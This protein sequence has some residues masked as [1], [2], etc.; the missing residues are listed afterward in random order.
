M[1]DF[2]QNLLEKIK[3]EENVRRSIEERGERNTEPNLQSL[4]RALDNYYFINK[5]KIYCAFLS[6]SNI[7]SKEIVAY[8]ADDLLLIREI[9]VAIEAQKVS[10]PTLLIYNYI[11]I[12]YE[13]IG[14]PDRATDEVF[15]VVEQR[16]K[17]NLSYY[18]TD[19]KLEL[20]SFLTN[21]CAKRINQGIIEYRN[22]FFILNNQIINL[23]YH[24]RSGSKLQLQSSIYE[25]MIIIALRIQG[26]RCFQTMQT[27]GLTPNDPVNGF[28]DAFEWTEKFAEYYK[29]KLDEKGKKSHYPYCIALVEFSRANY[30]KAYTI[31]KKTQA[32]GMFIG[33]SSK[34]LYLQ[35]L[36]EVQKT[37]M[38]F[39][40]KEKVYI[41]DVLE[42]FRALI[43]DEKGRK[44]QLTYQI[45]FYAEF[46]RLYRKLY[47]VYELS[48]MPFSKD[49][50]QYIKEKEHL[51]AQIEEIRFSYKEW[52]VEKSSQLK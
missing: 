52:F 50:N 22:K 49:N 33:M 2:N 30:I 6:Y 36:Y 25:N 16:V 12:L 1:I 23:R 47:K 3:H 18:S 14:N 43:R 11:R 10:N 31:L 45:Q 41:D 19:E 20:Y 37:E 8:A 39:L 7:V 17:E 24:G 42:A 15:D 5:L 46:E 26:D 27:V 44:K 38:Q 9:I 48:R 29:H 4:S 21:Y 51:R 35:V 40:T 13:N 34:L 28:Q 32:R